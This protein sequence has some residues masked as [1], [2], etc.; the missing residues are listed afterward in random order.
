VSRTL[1]VVSTVHPPDDPRIREKLIRSLGGD[2]E[3]RYATRR[4]GP[5]DDDGL[6]YRPLSGGRVARW[7]SA[8]GQMLAADVDAVSIHDPE[9][10][11]AGLATRGL[12][13]RPVVIDVHENVPA[14]ILT[15][16]QI[17][18]LARR[19]ASGFSKW[20]LAQ[21][22]RYLDVT[23]AEPG[24]QALFDDERPVFPNY[25]DASLLPRAEG[26]EAGPVV[27]VGDVREDRGA[28]DLALAAGDAGVQQLVFVGRCSDELADRLRDA[29]RSAGVTVD[30]M[31]WLPYRE[32]MQV[33]ATA[34][35]GVSPL[36]DEPNFRR[37]LPTK[38]LEY[39]SIGI[40]VIASDLPG[41]RAAI[42]DLAGVVL[43]PPSD[44][45]ALAAALV[46]VDAELQS[47]ARDGVEEVRRRF[48]WP[49]EEVREFY[50][51]LLSEEG[52]G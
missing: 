51:S 13:R 11:P 17:P 43:V 5:A 46:A 7:F 33:A 49:D 31:G 34:S 35:V 39:L 10:I 23:L 24:Y 3:I 18:A 37:S 8:L 42:G 29:G 47:D 15:K 19:P 52:A 26:N 22:E 4:P 32:A 9:L 2:W 1:L 44:R 6:T 12:R 30:V 38:T 45:E 27:Y 16:E 41:T 21:A 48:R 20:W 50:A 36:R 40:P 28:L 14:Q 25:P